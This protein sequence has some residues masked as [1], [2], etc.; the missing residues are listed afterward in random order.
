MNYQEVFQ[1]KT[2][3]DTLREVEQI[4]NKF[5]VTPELLASLV[6]YFKENF[7]FM[8]QIYASK[9]MK[10]DMFQELMLQPYSD[11]CCC[12]GPQGSHP[13]CNCTMRE[14]RYMY[15]YDIA[16]VLLEEGLI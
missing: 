14:L 4:E 2:M 12:M 7:E 3:A 10:L 15:R 11:A 13:Y 1:L 8:T 9:Q 6:Q 16:L 5:P